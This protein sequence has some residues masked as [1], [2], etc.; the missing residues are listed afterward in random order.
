MKTAF[1]L[2]LAALVGTLAFVTDGDSAKAGSI[3]AKTHG[4]RKAIYA[5][6]TARSKGDSITI[7]IN[8]VTTIANTT[9]RKAEKQTSRS[10]SMSGTVNG[11]NM[12]GKLTNKVYSIP[13]VAASGASDNKFDGQSDYNS[14]RSTTDA[15]TVTV[16][17][18]QPNGY[19]VVLGQRERN[20][21]GDH[22]IIQISGVVR[23]DD[24]AFDNSIDSSKVADFNM[25]IQ[26]KG[27]EGEFT[28]PGWFGKLLNWASPS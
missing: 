24:I 18:V 12:F 23:P 19:M 6:D 5:D 27:F 1:T 28:N 26:S 3:Y 8:E 21:C 4:P 14:S 13:T 25:V 20:I 22:Q 10:A 11:G 9:E 7:V 15:V 17:D 16:Q 2:A